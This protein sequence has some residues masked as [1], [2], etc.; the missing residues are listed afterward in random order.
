MEFTISLSDI[1]AICTI[2]ATVA[3]AWKIVNK[4]V[5]DFKNKLFKYDECLANDK[6]RLD[7]QDE[8]LSD[9]RE[10]LKMQGD[11]LYQILDHMA[12]NNNTGGMAD[13]LDRYNSFYRH[14]K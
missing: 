12:T 1:L 10:N 2:I 8:V 5:K 6:K 7:K 3:G 14:S 11:M 4:P 13:C 9:I